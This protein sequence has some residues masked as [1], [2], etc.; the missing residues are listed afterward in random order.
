MLSAELETAAPEVVAAPLGDLRRVAAVVAACAIVVY[1]GALW[2]RWA[3]DDLLF[4][5]GSDLV[6]SPSGVWRAFLEPYLPPQL[7]G[8]LYRPLV[9]ASYAIDWHIDGTTWFHAVN[10]LWHAGCAVLVATLAYRWL[11]GRAALFA[12]ICFAVHPVH[13][14]AVANV[15]GRAELMATGFTLLAVYAALERQSVLWCSA[16]WAL[17]LLSKENAAVAPLLV[18]TAWAMGFRR[19][20]AKTMIV[21]LGAW[22]A[23]GA[24]Y[25]ALRRHVLAPYSE[26][27]ILAPVF[28]GETWAHAKL[29]AV[30]SIADVARLLVV[31]AKLRADYSPDERTIV[32]TVFDGRF[33][34]GALCA[35][36]WLGLLALA[37]RRRRR[38]EALGLVWIAVAYAPV[39]N[40]ILPVGVLV[41]ERTLYL[42]SVGLTLAVAAVTRGLSNR[43][44]AALLGVIAV[45]GGIRTALRVPVWRSDL[46]ATL[47]VLEDS[48]RSY[49]GPLIVSARY[50]EQHRDS[51]ALRTAEIAAQIFPREARPYLIGAHA[52][53]NL[54]QLHLADSLLGRADRFCNP[55]RGYYDAQAVMAERLGEPDAARYLTAHAGRLDR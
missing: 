46:T 41:A 40:L 14:E 19:P 15:V 26:T 9:I 13:V 42:S 4:I 33:V 49:V 34:L 48:P 24:A 44:T 54:K 2:N 38:V 11:D 39:S 20:S 31:P 12:G 36:L 37:L 55:C 53:F 27:V 30:A 1:L 18:M 51:A 17:G 8:Y 28:V 45:A 22:L 32:T 35:L 23:V 10:I 21:Q 29:T 50:L 52:A 16:A 43:T 47:S 6:H 25:L 5:A 3:F 7:G